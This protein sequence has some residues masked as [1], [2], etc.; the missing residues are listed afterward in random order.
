MKKAKHI[1][2][3]CM[4]ILLCSSCTDNGTPTPI[5][6][7]NQPE[8]S[9]QPQQD[10]TSDTL[11]ADNLLLDENATPNTDVLPR[12]FQKDNA[13]VTAA[14][15]STSVLYYASQDVPFSYT[16]QTGAT[17]N[18]SVWL[19]RLKSEYDITLHLVRKNNA[20][21]LAAQSLAL[22]SGTQIDILS[23]TPDQLTYAG[24]L[25]A[26]ITLLGKEDIEQADYLN[27]TVLTYHRKGA[28]YL[29]PVGVARAL[30]YTPQ[31]TADDPYAL[32]QKK[33]WTL[34]AFTKYV[35][36]SITT[37]NDTVMRTGLEIKE[38]AQL[39]AALGTPLI[40][41]DQNGV[42]QAGDA[43]N[44]IKTLS[45]LLSTKGAC[46]SGSQ[47]DAPSLLDGT[48]AMRYGSTPFVTTAEKYPAVNWAP[49]PTADSEK[50][51]G[52]VIASAPVLALPKKSAQTKASLAAA[53]LYT[54]RFA[55]ANHDRMRFTYGLSFDKWKAYY[56]ASDEQL[57]IVCLPS[58]ETRNL[59]FELLTEKPD[60]FSEKWKEI[61]TQT[62][63]FVTEKNY[64]RY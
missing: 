23:F 37:E 7:P 20:T 64:E 8:Q 17:V 14:K 9:D 4:I 46:S 2:L 24:G 21:S 36:N 35:K 27:K 29:M 26:D 61:H 28:A 43:Q 55:D 12:G 63:A 6:S 40:A 10:D 11:S 54:A 15:G 56:I 31:N 13:W 39:L 59:L 50:R 33:E 52:C 58:A 60:D 34:S 49:L 1:L 25:A 51:A 18:D 38:T 3:I 57:E 45:D 47:K 53:L 5:P 42:L 32:S 16:D 19:R 62:E 48:L 41:I 30:W 44:N 22:L